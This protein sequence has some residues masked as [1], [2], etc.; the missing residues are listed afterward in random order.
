MR[1]TSV[2]RLVIGV[3]VIAGG[4]APAQEIDA[5][6]PSGPTPHAAAVTMPAD[7]TSITALNGTS[8]IAAGLADGQVAI[9]TTT[10]EP[11]LLKPHATTVL[12]VG[13]TRDG[14]EVW[15]VA[16]DGSLARTRVAAG[17][18]PAVQKI[19]LGAAAISGATFS[20]D[21][22]MLVTGGEFGV[23]QVFDT[24]TGALRHTLRGHRTELQAMAIRPDSALLASASAEADLKVWDLAAGRELSSTDLD[25]SMFTIG[26]SPADGTLAS[27]GVDRHV[28]FR[29]AATLAARGSL[30]LKAPLMVASLAWSPDGRLVAIG[31]IDDATL[32]KG[33]LRIVDAETRA[34]VTTLD[35][36]G[37]PPSGVT[38]IGDGRVLVAVFGPELRAWPVQ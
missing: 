38:F 27:G 19:D 35:T 11:L 14:T 34:A 13:S 15:S 21:G 25:L 20:A 24:S 26:F 10:S 23:L 8:S 7:I 32:S 36:G 12:A 28:T 1:A 22:S 31:D 16:D 9:W 5:A 6:N 37:A 18:S 29:D 17:A 3:S 4:C 33:A 2:L 30:D